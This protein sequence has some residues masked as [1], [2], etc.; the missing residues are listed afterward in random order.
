MSWGRMSTW[1][2]RWGISLVAGWYVTSDC[3]SSAALTLRLQ[4]STVTSLTK[5]LSTASSLPSF[6]PSLGHTYLP[7]VPKN[8]T[9]GSS[10]QATQASKEGT[11]MPGGGTPLPATQ[12]T[13]STAKTSKTTSDTEFQGV[14]M[15]AYSYDLSD[16]YGNE[17][18]DENPI[19]GEPG[20]FKLSKSHNTSLATSMTA[21]K[22]SSQAQ[23]VSK[24]S[25]QS[26][27][28]G[29]PAKSATS[30]APTPRLKTEDLPAPVRK[31]TKGSEKSP[32]TPGTKEKKSRRKS[33]AAGD[34]GSTTPK[35]TTPKP[36]TPA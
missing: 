2:L 14:Q 35:T 26:S 8:L 20:S 30:A 10:L 12:D 11:P 29:T 21:S 22:T 23:E 32:T 3:Y 28:V 15:L 36:T 5:L 19:V 4:L 13:A 7:P 9:P 17:Y 1:R 31:G 18:M 24:L 25:S 33:K 6:T 27:E 34:K 16:R